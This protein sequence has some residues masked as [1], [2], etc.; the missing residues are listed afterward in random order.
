M[1]RRI[2][3]AAVTAL[4]L[5]LLACHDDGPALSDRD[6]RANIDPYLPTENCKLGG[7]RRRG[8]GC[9]RIS[10]DVA[11]DGSRTVEARAEETIC[12]PAEGSPVPTQV[13]LSD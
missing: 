9:R 10:E 13:T 4:P 6:F 7:L 5:L 8:F 11:G 1:R 2:A 12:Q 3:F